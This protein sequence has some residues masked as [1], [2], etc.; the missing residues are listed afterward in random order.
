MFT[1]KAIERQA[2]NHAMLA[3]RELDRED[4]RMALE[5]AKLLEKDCNVLLDKKR[6]EGEG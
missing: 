5:H 2:R 4:Y 6:I 3:A 1:I